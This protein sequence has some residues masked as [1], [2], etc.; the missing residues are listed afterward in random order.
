[1]EE[2]FVMIC[3]VS[4]DMTG[5]GCIEL[6]VVTGEILIAEA[7]TELAEGIFGVKDVWTWLGMRLVVSVDD[8]EG[9][10]MAEEG[11]FESEKAGVLS[12]L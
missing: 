2:L 1:M 6:E 11:I 3:V 4:G 7:G 9:E 10:A 12:M 5:D 8:V